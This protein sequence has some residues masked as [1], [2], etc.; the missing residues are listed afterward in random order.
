[1]IEKKEELEAKL[2]LLGIN[3]LAYTDEWNK[4]AKAL[5]VVGV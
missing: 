3:G 4:I 5:S 2:I 1:M